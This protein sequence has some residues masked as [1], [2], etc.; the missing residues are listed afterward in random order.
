MHRRVALVQP[1]IPDGNFSPNLGLLYLAAVLEKS[2][3]QVRTFDESLDPGYLQKLLA[4][5]P[6]V[7]GFTVVTAAV[8]R[9]FQA[10]RRIKASLPETAVVAGGPHPSVLPEEVLACPGIDACVVG[11]GEFAFLELCEAWVNGG[12]LDGVANLV[13]RSSGTMQRTPCRPLLTSAELDA[14]PY[15]AFHLLDLESVFARMTHGLFRKGKRV[16]PIMTSRG[17]PYP[18]AFCCRTMGKRVRVR[19][20]DKVL[21]EIGALIDRYAIDEV[22]IED[23]NFTMDRERALAILRGIRSRFPG[24][25]VKFAN[26]LRA[27][28]VDATL[29]E[30]IRAAGGYWIGFGIE[31]GSPRVLGLMNKQ[32]DLERA[33]SIVA[34][35]KDRGFKTGSNLIIGYPGE[36]WSDILQS[37][38]FFRS[39]EL[40]SLAIVNLVPFPGTEVRAICEERGYLTAA[41]QDWDNYYF[42]IADVRPLVHTPSLSATDTKL[43]IWLCYFLFYGISWKRLSRASS[44]LA[45]RFLPALA[46]RIQALAA[47]PSPTGRPANRGTSGQSGLPDDPAGSRETH[48]APRRDAQARKA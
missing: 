32:L 4:Y 39:L 25:S 35:A 36:T 47:L 33:R 11:E 41:A 17:C 15:P 37:I 21:D 18:C 3:M 22:Y 14:L 34:L 2:G 26:G 19:A 1:R 30:A 12:T 20:A 43:A 10:A 27:D 29:L 28:R 48:R 38:R 42:G 46:E 45:M 44:S 9:V 16:L 23:D 13:R 8:K 40:D 6:S 7:V 24:L 31:S 5:R